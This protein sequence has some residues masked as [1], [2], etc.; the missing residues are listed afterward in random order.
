MNFGGL[1][2]PGA[3]AGLLTIDGDYTQAAGAALDIEIGGTAPGTQ[4]DRL[5]VT[6]T[7]ALDG[8]LDV[9]L[10]NA[11]DRAIGSTFVFLQAGSVVGAFDPVS[12]P[13]ADCAS[14]WNLT[15]NATNATLAL[16]SPPM[17]CATWTGA[18]GTGFWHTPGNWEAGVVPPAGAV[19]VIP[20]LPGTSAVTFSTGSVTIHSLTCDEPFVL[21]GGTLGIT[22]EGTFNS[23]YTQ[24]SSSV[25]TGAG[26]V[27]HNGPCVWTGGGMTG[28][29][30][31]TLQAG[32]SINDGQ[33]RSL[34]RTL[35][36]AGG[37][38]IVT[39]T[40]GSAF[41]MTAAATVNNEVGCTFDFQSSGGISLSGGGGGPQSFNNAGLLR[42]SAGGVSG[43]SCGVNNTGTIE[44]QTNLLLLFFNDLVQTAGEIV[45][46]NGAIDTGFTPIALQGG[47]LRGTG[48]VNGNLDNSG[49]VLEVGLSA[50]LLTINGNY[51]QTAGGTLDMEIG[52]TMAGTEYDQ[53]AVSGAVTLDGTLN[54]ALINGYERTGG[55]S[56]DLLTA[57]SVTGS[58]AETNLPAL[59]AQEWTLTY[60][61][62]AVNLTAE[63]P[64]SNCVHWINPA[65]GN[66]SIGANWDTGVAP[67]A[68]D[69]AIIDLPGTYTVTLNVNATVGGLQLGAP[70]GTQ[71][72][73]A[74]GRIVTLNGESAVG[75]HGVVSLSAS[76]INGSG[77][78]SN[79]GFLALD[80]A[81]TIA[82]PLHNQLGATLRVRNTNTINS[83]V[84]NA[85]GG[86]LRIETRRPGGSTFP[87]ILVC[88]A[89]LSNAGHIELTMTEGIVFENPHAEL[90][91]TG[92]VLLNQPGGVIDLLIGVGNSLRQLNGQ[93]DNQGIINVEATPSELRNNA[94]SQAHSNTGAINLTLGNL[95]L[96]N[97]G[98]ANCSF[99]NSG[100]LTVPAG[101]TLSVSG[102][103]FTLSA[104][105]SIVQ[106]ATGAI[107][108][109]SVSLTL[110]ADYTSVGTLSLSSS[111]VNGPGALISAGFLAL[112]GF[113]TLNT[114]VTNQAG[115]TIRV[116]NT[117][118]INGGLTN[119]VGGLVRIETRRPGG[120]TIPGILVC[121]AG[122]SNAGRIELTMTEGIVFENPHAVL[123]VTGGVLLN[124]PGGVIDLL[125]GVGNSLRQLNGQLDNQ[126]TINV[127]ASPSELRHNAANQ[128]HS[129]SGAINLT[130]GNLTVTNNLNPNCSMVHT[131][132]FNVAMGRA[133]TITGLPLNIPHGDLAGGGVV[134]ASAPNTITLPSFA[135]EERTTTVSC[136]LLGTASILVGLDRELVVA[137]GG[138]IDRSGRGAG[139]G[140]LPLSGSAGW[141]TITVDGRIVV[142]GTIQNSKLTINNDVTV[143][144]CGNAVGGSIAAESSGTVQCCVL[145]SFSDRFFDSD[146]L[147]PVQPTFAGNSFVLAVTPD[148]LPTEQ[149]ELLELR[150]ADFDNG[151]GMGAPGA[152]QLATSAGDAMGQGYSSVWTPQQLALQASGRVNLINRPGLDYNAA[153]LDDVLYVHELR[154]GPNSV[155]NYGTQRMYYRNLLLTDAIGNV[156]ATNPPPP[157]SNGT[158][159][160]SIPLLG[161]SLEV[162]HMEDDCEFGV[163]VRTP[164]MPPIRIGGSDGVVERIDTGPPFNTGVM[165]MDTRAAESVSAKGSFGP[166]AEDDV[167]VKFDYLFQQN[168]DA[169]L[170]VYLS[171][172]SDLGENLIE[173]ARVNP[174]EPGRAGA[175]GSNQFAQFYGVFPRGHLALHYGTFVEVKLVGAN[176]R[177]WIDNFDPLIECLACA[178]LNGNAGVEG[179]DY[180]L[181]LAS[182]GT[183]TTSPPAGQVNTFCLD[184][185]LGGDKYVDLA[186]LLAW[187]TVLNNTSALNACGLDLGSGAPSAGV[188]L[189]DD[190]LVVVGKGGMAGQQ[191]DALYALDSAGALMG[192]PLE[193]ASAAGPNGQ[194]RANGRLASD[195]A[196][197]LHQLHAAQGLIRL[198]DAAVAIAP[199]TAIFGGDTVDVGVTSLFDGFGGYAGT[200]IL[201]AAFAPGDPTRVY[202]VPVIVTPAGGGFCEQYRAAAK[203]HL[204]GG[205]AFEIEQLY[206]PP[207]VSSTTGCG[208]VPEPALGGL[209]EIEVSPDGAKLFISS[210][211]AINDNDWLLAFNASSG[212]LEQQV[213]LSSLLPSSLP[214]KAPQAMTVSSTGLYLYVTSG[215][216]LS[217]LTRVFRFN[218]ESG[219]TFAG[220]LDITQPPCA[221]L[222]LGCQ[223]TIN[224]LAEKPSTGVLWVS[225]YTSP[226]IATDHPFNAPPFNIGGMTGAIYTTATLA[227]IPP[228]GTW[229]LTPPATAGAT[230]SAL[231]A[232][233]LALPV[234]MAFT[235]TPTA[236][237][238]TDGDQDLRDFAVLSNCFTGS[239]TFAVGSA[240]TTFN[241]NCDDDI[242]AADFATLLPLSGP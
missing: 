55:G 241:L 22:I 90:T 101:R 123:T 66:W 119:P 81:N 11:F 145:T 139:G 157:F 235:C 199:A 12:L 160:V 17:A 4:Y 2:R 68:T 236:D 155:L 147:A 56:F 154:L 159:I 148:N 144:S 238:D 194:Q 152:Y 110:G 102:L 59:C 240:C 99:N 136:H 117:N 175:I 60:E 233:D 129:N 186:D 185:V 29:G 231:S 54:V 43:I 95:T 212:V 20:D 215:V 221:D 179:Q 181:L 227:Q 178:D 173:V 127:E 222:G 118:T 38:T 151:V 198:S 10:I 84:T 41:S 131:G 121:T 219:V 213:P 153:A 91:V 135:S 115:A 150:S 35:N 13:P 58:F 51:V 232:A 190:A 111:T 169:E 214:L 73:T 1:V 202:V 100:V 40:S 146:P 97:N 192:A 14:S 142:N 141:G 24:S 113:S 34:G 216:G 207:P 137:S 195:G 209:R 69:I 197:E 187:D 162:I 28:G 36:N 234:A 133:L 208:A 5:V 224:G 126:G 124:Q 46:L 143:G 116:R 7:A 161:F 48:F 132:M 98:F 206:T 74:S 120:S 30:V 196:G 211:Q 77:T 71:T 96:T 228:S 134:L 193:P 37:G 87:G 78:L 140:C 21:S 225:G 223:A 27:T 229:S 184:S 16:V 18:A 42:K 75:A 53:L 166:S 171:D 33:F 86:L 174:P 49:G 83:T 112:D 70:T 103:A 45:L 167:V 149:G 107:S 164:P 125:I 63:L 242:D 177:V 165:N 62:D 237:A 170:I 168:A 105:G 80:G 230:A 220:V 76:T 130:A 64:T 205:G 23:T 65:G 67:G 138:V 88:T 108:A 85:S 82:V 39:S 210:A 94:P 89:G 47:A 203:L 176:S 158:E 25:L 57:D 191:D 31:T 189:P 32:M 3:S 9:T 93:L 26:Q 218:L 6:G 200:P 128:A 50:G 79:A 188:G 19:V 163:R 122:V 104:G 109:A 8:A 72:L 106:A 52:G 61:P 183:D 204:L 226:T 182:I 239:G 15:Y 92:G 217:G 180:L 44:V 201:D 172:A 114:P 156:I